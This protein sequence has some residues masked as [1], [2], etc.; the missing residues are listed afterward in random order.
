MK[1]GDEVWILCACVDEYGVESGESEPAIDTST[2]GW[3]RGVVIE[4]VTAIGAEV[5]LKLSDSSISYYEKRFLLTPE[6]AEALS[7]ALGITL[8]E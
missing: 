5:M 1:L 6:R 3:L 4:E 2:F 8:S 7:T